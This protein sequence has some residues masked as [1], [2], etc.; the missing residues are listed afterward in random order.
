V[1]VNMNSDRALTAFSE[2]LQPVSHDSLESPDGRAK[3]GDV[4]GI[5]RGGETTHLGETREDEDERPRC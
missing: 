5:E 1:D 2:R 4:L 3:S